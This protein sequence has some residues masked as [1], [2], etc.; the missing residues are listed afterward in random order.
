MASDQGHTMKVVVRRT[1]LSPHVIRMWE[2]RYGAVTPARTETRR[3]L[4][5]ETEIARL[6]LLRQATRLGH[7]ISQV[8]ALPTEQL[9]ILVDA[10]AATTTLVPPRP[11][12]HPDIVPAQSSI[13]ACMA[14][15]ERLNAVEL[16]TTL[17]RA[18]VM[19]SHTAFVDNVIVPLMQT[20]GELWHEGALRIMHEHLTSAVVRTLLGSLTLAPGLPETAPHIIVTT[21]AGQWHE[22]GALLIASTASVDGWRVTYLGPNLPA[23]DMAAAVQHDHARAIGLSIIYPPDDPHLPQELAKLRRY[24]GSDVTIFVGGRVSADYQEILA[25]LGVVRPRD[26]QEFR[27]HLEALRAG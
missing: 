12:A 8:A 18:R 1:G 22:I 25:S 16:E 10:D 2:K 4:Y 9:R 26:L 27:R 24:L 15:V 11:P 19:L 17:M 7:S 6:V 5:T 23:E 20:I 21:P 14:A 3:R 13:D